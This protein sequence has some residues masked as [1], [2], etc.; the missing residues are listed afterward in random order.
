MFQTDSNQWHSRFR[1]I[2]SV[3]LLIESDKCHSRFRII[4]SVMW[5]SI[6]RIICIVMLQIGNWLVSLKTEHFF[7]RLFVLKGFNIIVT[8]KT[9]SSPE[10]NKPSEV[11]V[12]GVF[13]VERI[14]KFYQLLIKKIAPCVCRVLAKQRYLPERKQSWIII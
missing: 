14:S 12:Y 8:W 1:I 4:C 9:L 11:K 3:M 2:C 5:H 6:V 7:L 13:Q 10:G